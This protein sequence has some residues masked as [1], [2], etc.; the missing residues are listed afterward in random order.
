VTLVPLDPATLRPLPGTAALSGVLVTLAFFR[1]PDFARS[2]FEGY[3]DV[4]ET[5]LLGHLADDTTVTLLPYGGG[6]RVL[7]GQGAGGAGDPAAGGGAA[8]TADLGAGG[9]S[10]PDAQDHS[11]PLAGG[12]PADARLFQRQL[13]PLPHQHGGIGWETCRC[14]GQNWEMNCMGPGNSGQRFTFLCTR[15]MERAFNP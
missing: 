8:P 4:Y 7:P 3:G 11:Q 13:S 14:T 5:S 2:R 1:D 10:G 6:E 9:G 15:L 12:W